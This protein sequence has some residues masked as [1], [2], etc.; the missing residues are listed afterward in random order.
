MQHPDHTPKGT[1]SAEEDAT[2][3]LTGHELLA[4]GEQRRRQVLGDAHVD[5]SMANAD[6]FTLPMQEMITKYC[7][8]DVWNRPQIPLKTRSLINIGM[9][10]AMSQSHEL[11]VHVKGAVNN[12]CT[13]EE[14][15]EVVLQATIYAG[16]PAGLSALRIVTQTLKELDQL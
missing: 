5:K 12:G 14:I 4:A 15:R 1:R 9:L 7:W 13:P 8:G 2:N 11:S 3:D 10:T 16:A 6:P